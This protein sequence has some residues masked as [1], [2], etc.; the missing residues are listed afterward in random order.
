[1]TRSGEE[2]QSVW[3]DTALPPHREPLDHDISADVC[4]VGAGIAG[5]TTAHLLLK[6]GQSVAIVDGSTIG[7]GQ[8][9]RTTAHLSN[10]IDDRYFEIERLH[11]EQGAKMAAESHT[12]AIRLIETTVA[13]ENIDCGFEYLDGH[14]FAAPDHGRDILEQEL[15]AC[16]RA[17]LADVELSAETPLSSLS[18]GGCLRFPRQGQFHPLRY[19]FGLA[20]TILRRG[21]RI[22]TDTHVK[23]IDGGT[24]AKVQTADGPVVTCKSVVVATNTPINDL[25]TMHTKQAAYRTYALAAEVPAKSVP[26]ALY[27]DTA[28]P[29][30]YIRLQE[31]K[32]P[33]ANTSRQLLIVGG[34]DHKTG[35]PGSVQSCERL[36]S[37]ARRHFPQMGKVE[38]F[39]SGQVMETI[40]GLAFIGRNPGDHPNVFIATGDSGMGMTHG[41]I[42]G[43]L[44]R[45]LI[46]GRDHRW[47]TLYD[48]AR[49]TMRAAGQFTRENLNVAWQYTD[50]MTKGEVASADEISPDS[51]AVV[52]SGL[53]KLAIYRDAGGK[54]HERSAVC[55]HLGCIVN[56]NGT[57]KTW[58][59]PCHG[60]R[61]DR[62]GKVICGPTVS[63]LADGSAAGNGQ[64]KQSTTSRASTRSQ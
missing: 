22:F 57:E 30:H 15:A 53:H 14:L 62:Y 16:H 34:E 19:L 50:W 41:T 8:T 1:M 29:Y 47:A 54:L 27:W 25:V 44:L 35:Q 4:I 55:P 39:W 63:N 49:K 10:A 40:D 21:G 51:G 5:L 23:R 24:P 52:R 31:I 38:Y 36:E 11:G 46:L 42:A 58:D 56:W 37:W 2:T 7:G 9:Q 13:E 43:M 12:A 33:D 45:D 18:A 20:Q 61:F 6:K 48:P 28:D 26:K 3:M 64:S 17:G 60:S 59:C 32:T